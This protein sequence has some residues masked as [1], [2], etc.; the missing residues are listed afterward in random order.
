[1]SRFFANKS[2]QSLKVLNKNTINKLAVFFK[3]HQD[4][5]DSKNSE[6][7]PNNNSQWPEVT[8]VID[9]LRKLSKNSKETRVNKL[10]VSRTEF[11]DKLG[12]VISNLKEVEQTPRMRQTDLYSLLTSDCF[13]WKGELDTLGK[14]EPFIVQN[15]FVLKERFE[16]VYRDDSGI[17]YE[18]AGSFSP[19]THQFE[20]IGISMDK[21]RSFKFR[22]EL[23]PD[24]TLQG[25]IAHRPSIK[26]LSSLHLKLLGVT[27]KANLINKINH[28]N[29]HK[30]LPCVY[31]KTSTLIYIMIRIDNTFVFGSGV[32]DDETNIF[33][34]ELSFKEKKYRTEL[35]VQS[36]K[37][38]QDLSSNT[39]RFNSPQYFLE[40]IVDK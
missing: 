21:D 38:L 30:N 35:F 9:N 13:L 1:M 7:N 16:G 37:D 10:D 27:A 8:G 34:L 31:K 36:Q 29:S 20:I 32:K 25:E 24:F 5:N 4:Q 28:S 19:R 22:G 33:S 40:L 39:L 12:N 17:N 14:Q 11:I 6:E 23:K 2:R 26:P 18:L 3:E 15:L